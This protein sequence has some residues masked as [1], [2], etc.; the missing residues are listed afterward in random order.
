MARTLFTKERN[1]ALLIACLFI[2]ILNSIE[3]FIIARRWKNKSN[4]ERIIFSLSMSD[5]LVGISGVII[6]GLDSMVMLPL[7]SKYGAGVLLP[8]WFSI[9][10]SLLHILGMTINR[11][12]AVKYPV[13]HKLMITPSRVTFSLLVIW[14]LS[15]MLTVVPFFTKDDFFILKLTAACLAVIFGF[16]IAVMY[17]F[18]LRTVIKG[19]RN[20]NAKDKETKSTGIKTQ[21]EQEIRLTATCSAIV[22]S[23]L[24]FMLSF[25]VDVIFNHGDTS[26]GCAML[27]VNSITNPIIYFYGVGP[28]KHLCCRRAASKPI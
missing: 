13:Q 4:H 22:I 11:A 10:T 27:Y 7:S 25:S 2:I 6:H 18:L 28:L 24:L 26:Y 12:I 20:V 16:A 19:K 8:L 23:F 1:I 3:A 5:L 9:N 21:R 17:A 15:L 14:L